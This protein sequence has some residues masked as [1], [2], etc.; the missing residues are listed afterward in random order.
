MTR[1]KVNLDAVNGV[2]FAVESANETADLAMK[3]VETATENNISAI[4]SALQE[5]EMILNF[6]NV[7]LIEILRVI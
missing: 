3:Q 7:I 6:L 1:A 2:R 4:E 5:I